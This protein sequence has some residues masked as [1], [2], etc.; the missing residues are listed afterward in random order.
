MVRWRIV[1]SLSVVDPSLVRYIEMDDG[2]ASAPRIDIAGNGDCLEAEFVGPPNIVDIPARQPVSILLSVNDGVSWQ[3]IY[4]GFVVSA[5]SVRDDGLRSYRCVGLKRRRYE[6]FHTPGGRIAG[7]DL[8]T[9]ARSIVQ[10]SSAQAPLLN[11]AAGDR[12]PAPDESLGDTLDAFAAMAGPFVV[13]P[14]TSYVYAG[15]TYGAGDIVPGV[16][17]GVGQNAVTFFRRPMPD[18]FVEVAETD[19]GVRVRWGDVT[20]EEAVNRVRLVFYSKPGMPPMEPPTPGAAIGDWALVDP[21]LAAVRPI[22]AEFASGETLPGGNSTRAVQLA[23]PLDYLVKR[24]FTHVVGSSG[25]PNWPYMVD[26]SDTTYGVA[27]TSTTARIRFIV[28]GHS[29][30]FVLRV[31]F[32]LP[33]VSD[34]LR[35]RARWSDGTQAVA[36]MGQMRFEPNAE[37]LDDTTIA[38]IT[39]LPTAKIDWS[40]VTLMEVEVLGRLST[41]VYDLSVWEPEVSDTGPGAMLARAHYRTPREEAAE[42]T[43]VG[44]HGAVARTVRLTPLGGEP[45]DLPVERVSYAITPENGL[46]TTYHIGQAYPSELLS[47]RAV[48]ERLAERVAATASKGVR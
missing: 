43:L 10:M 2:I 15:H 29:A 12:Y 25:W 18:D 37:A 21:D 26:G 3:R 47:Q 17:W 35:L 40:A 41:R 32:G 24:P 34:F 44:Q 14:G 11:F 48:L 39:V 4:A 7:D 16:E 45:V 8:A 27:N 1:N 30:P 22:V 31:M 36:T 6:A 13:P 9:M 42:V 46:T 19:E 38:Y 28:S 5:G 33:G 20:G 23:A